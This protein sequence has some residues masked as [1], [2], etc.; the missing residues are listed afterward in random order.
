MVTVGKTEPGKPATPARRP[1]ALPRAKLIWRKDLTPDIMLIK[2]QPEIPFTFKPGQYCTLGLEGIERAYSIV[3]A[4]H[5]PLLE[6]FVELVPSGE[7]TPRMW[8]LKVGD[9][10]SIRPTAK[11]VFTM[12][13]RHPNQFMLG[14]VTGVAPYVSIIRS[15]LHHKKS[16]HRFF[17]LYGAS[18][19]DECP[20]SEEMEGLAAQHPEFIAYVPTV[21]RPQE[22]RNRGWRGATGR[23]NT[24]AEEWAQRFGLQTSNTL[25]YA[26][27]HPGMI[28]DV[29]QR[30]IPKGWKVKEERFWK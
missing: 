3:S 11:G 17:V 24:I 28:E 15:Y 22:E 6:I 5:E 23:V 10:M 8:K 20:Y 30:F 13:E 9:S 2:L 29:K 1:V 21:S 16:G 27:G 25:V 26:C 7:L 4:P 12:D 19:Q 14:T 18:Y